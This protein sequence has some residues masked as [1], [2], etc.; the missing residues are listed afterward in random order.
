MLLAM[1]S[2]CKIKVVF[3]FGKGKKKKKRNPSVDQA[4]AE[5]GRNRSEDKELIV[6]APVIQR[7]ELLCPMHESEYQS[8][9]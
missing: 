5:L 4:T 7:E 8:P 3:K 9:L 6:R 1:N 2:I